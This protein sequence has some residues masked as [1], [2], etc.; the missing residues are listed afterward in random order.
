MRERNQTSFSS[1]IEADFGPPV[2]WLDEKFNGG[3]SRTHLSFY[4]SKWMLELVI[5]PT[6]WLVN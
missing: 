6:G 4:S 1:E 2:N 5:N 3:G